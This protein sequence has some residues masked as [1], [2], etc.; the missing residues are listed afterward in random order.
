[1][2]PSFLDPS[3]YVNF[4]DGKLKGFI[5]IY[6]DDNLNAGI[7]YFEKVTKKSLKI[8]DSKPQIYD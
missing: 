2:T 8:F 3:L 7:K 1:M 5:L 6:V 4:L